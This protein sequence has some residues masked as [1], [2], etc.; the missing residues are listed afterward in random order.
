MM[1]RFYKH[2]DLELLEQ[3]VLVSSIDWSPVTSSL[4]IDGKSSNC[5]NVILDM[6]DSQGVMMMMMIQKNQ[7]ACWISNEIINFMLS[8]DKANNHYKKFPT[9]I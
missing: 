6:F 1:R 5:N 7:T 8:G 9:I 3:N 4:D 2:M